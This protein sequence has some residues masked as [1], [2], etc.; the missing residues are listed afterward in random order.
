MMIFNPY[1]L[2]LLPIQVGGVIID[3]LIYGYV[4]EDYAFRLASILV[5]LPVP[6]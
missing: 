4:D 3:C 2:P 6:I 1:D 5:M